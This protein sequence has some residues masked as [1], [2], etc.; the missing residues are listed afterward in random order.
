MKCKNTQ[1]PETLQTPWRLF[2]EKF[3]KN[4]LALGGTII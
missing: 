3:R 1:S 4:K 2:W